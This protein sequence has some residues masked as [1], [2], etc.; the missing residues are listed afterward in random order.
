MGTTPSETV[1]IPCPHVVSGENLQR[2]Q[3][4]PVYAQNLARLESK[5][6]LRSAAGPKANDSEKGITQKDGDGFEIDTTSVN[7]EFCGNSEHTLV[8]KKDEIES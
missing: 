3:H 2:Q 6:S 5:R 7:M 8:E 1:P 4:S